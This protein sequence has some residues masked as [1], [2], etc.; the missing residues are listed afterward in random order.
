MLG[1]RASGP[2]RAVRLGSVSRAVLDRAACP[3]LLL[4][5]GGYPGALTTMTGRSADS[6]SPREVEP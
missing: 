5:R 2:P 1:S 6:S 4:P 3:V